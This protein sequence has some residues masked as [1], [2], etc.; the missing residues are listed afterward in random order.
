MQA[1]YIEEFGPPGAIRHGALP[2]PLPGPADVLVDTLAVSVNPVDTFVRAGTWRTRLS[3]P[4]VIG[5]DLVGTV[6]AVGSGAA[7]FSVGDLVWCNSLG[8]DGR[9]GAAAE[10]AVVPVERLYHLADTVRPVDAVAVLHP[11]ATGY[12]ALFTHGRLRAGETV[13]VAGAAGNVGSAMVVLAVEAG[14]RVLA[15][16]R[17][18][19][20]E[21]CLGLGAT[22]VVDYRD[23]GLPE[24]VRDLSP[25]GVDLFVDTSGHNDLPVAVDLLAFRG[26]VVLLAGLR[27]RPVLPVGPLYLKDGSVTGFV[28]S[29]ATTCELADAARTLNRLLATGRLR[30][31]TVEE[32]PLSG[33]AEA[34]ARLER[35]ELHGRRVVLLPDR[36]R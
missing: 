5:R 17:P 2:A 35:G 12:L 16:A 6:A 30:A 1:A 29:R 19:D 20:A 7:G 11:A 22:A 26:R 31:R 28:I 18:E 34:H 4:F 9:Q 15:T 21:Y 10:Q 3:F 8:H 13:L 14:A 24:R 23:P 36:V 33:A 32:Q 27:S 25:H